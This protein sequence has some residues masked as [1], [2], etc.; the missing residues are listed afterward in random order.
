MPKQVYV[1]PAV[2]ALFVQAKDI[3]LASGG[4][5]LPPDNDPNAGYPVPV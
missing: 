2:E 3:M 4:Q 5:E 1:D